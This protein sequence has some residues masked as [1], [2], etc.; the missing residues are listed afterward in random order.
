MDKNIIF[1]DIEDKSV[2]WF[3]HSNQYVVLEKRTAQIINALHQNVPLDTISNELSSEFNIPL[4]EAINFIKD[5]EKNILHTNEQGIDSSVR[6]SDKV[7]FPDQYIYS[8][9]Y[10]IGE[11]IFKIDFTTEFELSLV[12]PKFAHLES[13]LSKVADHYLQVF[14]YNE[15]TFL[16]VNNGCIGSWT[17]P[18][19]HYFQGKLSMELIQLLHQKPE[20]DWLGVFHA[21]AVS[22]GT[23]GMLFLG[24]SGNGKSTSLALLQAHGF[25]CIADDFVPVGALTQD[26]FSFPAAISIKKNSLD[27]LIP[28]Y[29]E[30]QTTAEYHFER[31]KKIV[32]FLPPKNEKAIVN[33]PCKGFVFIKYDKEV[34]FQLT[35]ISSIEAFE[36]LV[37]DSWLSPI[38]ENVD[39]FL[40][41]FATIPCY[42]ITY[43]NN[44]HMIAEV[45][46]LFDNVL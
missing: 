29:P 42:K 25:H 24:D 6:T 23:N 22:D 27:T 11:L 10:K 1:K 20:K 36:K 13:T 15:R 45:S 46:K 34:D 31:L 5:L 32:R 16:Y 40:S 12:H 2:V 39:A 3:E 4:E 14:T 44:E 8:K 33:V 38:Y 7:T 21:S 30:L 9:Y 19:I 28:F 37:P 17:Y 41:W 43:A 18:D 26:I 35:E